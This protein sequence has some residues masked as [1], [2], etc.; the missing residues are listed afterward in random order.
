MWIGILPESLLVKSQRLV[1]GYIKDL[2]QY[3]LL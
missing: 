2:D 3:V 1:P